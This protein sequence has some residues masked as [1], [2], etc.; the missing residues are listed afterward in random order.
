M[1]AGIPSKSDSELRQIARDYVERRIFTDRNCPGDLLTSVFMVAALG[2]LAEQIQ[3]L[4]D[5]PESDA[6]LGLIYEYL[7]DAGPR[8]VNGYPMF[9]SLK[10]LNAKDALLVG[11]YIKEYEGMQSQ[12]ATVPE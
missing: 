11:G 12:F 9:M 1:S 2:G 10:I 7:E 8:S 5:N 6:R 4:K 3:F